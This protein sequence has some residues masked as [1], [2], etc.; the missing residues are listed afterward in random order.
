MEMSCQ[1]NGNS[2]DIQQLCNSGGT[3]YQD[4]TYSGYMPP[5]PPFVSGWMY[6]NEQ[7]QMC[8]PYI[9]QQLFEGLSTGFLPDELPVYPV[10]NGALI[11]PIPLK[12]FKQFPDHVATGFAYLSLGSISSTSTPTNSLK[13]CNG[14]LATIATCSIPTPVAT[15]YPDLQYDSTSQAS[16]DTSV[17]NKLIL[18]SKAPN[19]VTS[20]QS[21]SSKDSCW[22]YEDEEGK[23]NGPYSLFELNSWHRYGYL[24]D[25][26]TIYHV[27]NKCKPFT[28]SSVL[29]SW[30][31]D[32]PETI[33]KF[34][35][36]CNGPLVSIISEVTEGVSSQLHYGI[37][38][39]ARRVV[40][41]EIISNVIAEFVTTTK[42][43]RLNQ[44]MK[45][46]SLDAKKSEIDG[47]AGVSG[48]VAERTCINQDSPSPMTKSVGSIQNFWDS[49]A[50]VCRMLFDYCM[51]VM[52]NA[53]FYDSVAEYS[54]AWRRRKLWTG[55]PLLWRP[56]NRCGDWVEK[57]TKLPHEILSDNDDDRPPGF[58]LLGAELGRHAQPSLS[59]SLVLMEEKPPKQIGPSYEDMKYIVEHIE[60]ELQ[61]TAKSSLT[62]YVGCFVDEEV[63]KLVN[64]STEENS[65]KENIDCSPRSIGGS[66]DLCDNLRNSNNTSAEII[67]SEICPTPEVEKPFHSSFPENRMSNFLASAFKEV[68]SH[69]DDLDGDQEVNEPSP[70]GL[71]ANVKTLG[72]SP[73][74]KFRPSRSEECIPKIGAYV[75]TA[76]L[77]KKL[78]DDVI[79]EWKSSF[80]DLALNK[81]LA[82]WRTSRKNHIRNEE[83]ACN[84]NKEELKHC[85]SSITAE[86]S[87]VIDEYTYQRKR[88]RKKS[89]S[90]GL[91]TVIDTG[92]KS[93][94]V[95]K[96]KKLHV[97]R[98]VPKNATVIPRKRSL[99]KLQTESSVDAISVK[100]N[101]KRLSS[102]DK[103]A[104]KNASCRKPLKG[105]H[106]QSCE[107][108]DNV[109][110][111]ISSVRGS[112][113]ELSVGAIALQAIDKRCSSADTL[114]ANNA[115]SRK[116]LKVSHAVK[117]SEPVE[118]TPK[119]SKRMVSAHVQDHND[120]ENVVNSHGR[121]DQLKGE[122]LTKVLKL[123]RERPVGGSQLPHPKKVLK[124][125]NDV[126]KQ[127]AN[128]PVA[129]R[130][131]RSSKSK[132]SNPCPKSDGC[133][134]ASINGWEW[135]RWSLNAT[136]AER[137]RVRGIKYVN[138]QYRT[139]DTNTSQWSNGKGLSARTNRVKMRSLLAAAEGADLLKATQLKARK[140]RLRF[141]RSKIH[142]WGLIALEPIEAED[143][144]IEYVGELIRPQISDIRERHYEKMGIGS[145]YLFRID[146]G[147]VVDATKRGGIARF[148][149]HSCEPN[150]YTK[151]ISV[152]GEKKIFIYA[153]RHIA[154]GEEITYNYKFPLEEKKIPC[155]CGSKRCRGSLN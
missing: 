82:S 149:N 14:D 121:D 153:K 124:V 7:G 22:L 129:V 92:L 45:T 98:N 56:P 20:N 114:V 88:L 69:V 113:T 36:K 19:Q 29:N 112:Q 90:S 142:D 78:H 21:L 42:A 104:A 99:S 115:I 139:S 75:A 52:W 118:C 68:C 116:R 48:Y 127:A 60:N 135:H 44:D 11:N 125:A 63:S 93:E 120:I 58:E 53:V 3:P 67:L 16:Y 122:P 146:D 143:F 109:I 81:F 76:M 86:V 148:I 32:G 25:S 136:P 137:A 39:S 27:K 96:A 38:K 49:Y 80:I 23:R 18:N 79:G 91:V 89:G 8:G 147:Y 77:R 128:I 140:K 133:A 111:G 62:E 132:T 151:V 6:V 101:S 24:R 110:D 28:L 95:E 134:R 35:A 83:K 150:C 155:N 59:S 94:T 15:G 131:A 84:T 5:P 9:Q 2:S 138:A 50:V 87:P 64:L 37:M 1:S 43:Q 66:S 152:E 123:K 46:C 70:P 71:I 107:P 51:E 97:A 17:S 40:L 119:P 73:I 154:A 85:H 65:I 30:K 41:D 102:T 61:L 54:S 4:K 34:D 141:Q 117:G 72:Q 108:I 33:T 103:S 55:S 26:L 12:Y 57:I 100:V 145:S 13:S 126:L 144:V 130:K 31:L 105:S 106:E 74:C 10:V 47:E